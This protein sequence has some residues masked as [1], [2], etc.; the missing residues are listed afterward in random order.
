MIGYLERRR[1]FEQLAFKNRNYV[2]TV[3]LYNYI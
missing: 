1:H 2:I 3:R